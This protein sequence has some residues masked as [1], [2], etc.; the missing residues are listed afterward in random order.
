MQTT[1]LFPLIYRNISCDELKNLIPSL[2]TSSFDFS[3]VLAR[4][5]YEQRVV[6]YKSLK[7]QLPQF[8]FSVSDFSLILKHLSPY[9]RMDF[10]EAFK[11]QLPQLIKSEEDLK[12][13]LKSLTCTE[14]KLISVSFKKYL[15][16]IKNNAEFYNLFQGLDFQKQNGACEPLKNRYAS[17]EA[18]INKYERHFNKSN[19]LTKEADE[20]NTQ[21]VKADVKKYLEHVL[22]Q[23]RKF[24]EKNAWNGQAI[25]LF[26]RPP[27]GIGKIRSLL[28][29]TQL[30]EFEKFNELYQI[31]VN[32][33]N[34]HSYFRKTI[35]KNFYHGLLV[36]FQ[37]IS[38]SS[39]NTRTVLNQSTRL[40]N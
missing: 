13:L 14:C 24:V 27:D 33:C 11:T 39:E 6:I 22:S 21:E 28:A 8:I 25:H 2:I 7:K 4:L 32:K 10:C 15:F 9:Y 30:D 34:S 26:R 37:E 18:F 19:L 36:N 31:L 5:T 1:K 23:L 29:N 38:A 40:R 35:T 17:I 16:S 20:L 3:Q 12:H